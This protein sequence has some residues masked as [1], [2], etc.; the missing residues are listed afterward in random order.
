MTTNPLFDALNDSSQ[1]EVQGAYNAKILYILQDA[2][3]KAR[4]R[5][6]RRRRRSRDVPLAN[7]PDSDDDD[8]DVGSLPLTL[9]SLSEGRLP[10]ALSGA[11]MWHYFYDMTNLPGKCQGDART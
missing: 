8:V 2:V 11:V 5:R 9:M 6:R 7:K 4:E 10:Q 3:S 1:T